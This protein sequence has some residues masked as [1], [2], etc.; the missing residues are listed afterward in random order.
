MTGFGKSQLELPSKTVTI[1][2]KSLNSKQLDLNIRT[3]SLYREKDLEIRTL[4]SQ[5]LE[6]GRVD[7]NMNVESK[8]DE[9]AYS[10]NKSLALK[11]FEQLQDLNEALPDSG[12]SY[13][14]LSILVRMPD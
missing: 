14:M 11:Y 3:P 9:E 13:D 8:T 6:R 1:E 12:K 2:I 7:F 4:I 5:K 10:I